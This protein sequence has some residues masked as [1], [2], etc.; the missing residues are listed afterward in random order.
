M[1]T[2]DD[3]LLLSGIQHFLYCKRQWALIHIEQQWSE[4]ELTAEGQIM[5]ARAH[6]EEKE[7]REGKLIVRGLRIHSEELGLVG[8][9]DVVEFLFSE[10]GVHLDGR[11]GLYLPYPVEYKH[12][13]PKETDEDKV[14]L[15][16][17]AMCLEE[18]LAVNIQEGAIFYGEIRRREAVDFS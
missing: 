5:H 8:Q 7:K 17:Q 3:Y 13:A 14:Q 12:G 1:Y 18:M 10:N 2:E 16:A 9:C 11:E 6:S 4:N 15:C